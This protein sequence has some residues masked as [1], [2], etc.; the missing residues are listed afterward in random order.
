M[1]ATTI[2]VDLAKRV[3]EVAVANRTC[4]VIARHRFTRPQFE[5]FL[6]AQPPAHLVMEACASAHHWGRLAR[7]LGH[8]VSLIPAQYVRPYVQRNKTDRADAEAVLEAS[9][10]GRVHPVPVKTTSQQELLALHRIRQQWMTTRTARINA[11]R[12]FLHEHGLTL[13][14]GARAGLKALPALLADADNGLPPRLRQALGWLYE[15]IRTVEHHVAQLERELARAAAGDV[16]IQRLMGIPGIGLL[17]ATALVATVGDI[18]AFRR[19]R[20]FAS[21]LGLTP[22][23]HSSGARRRLGAISKQGDVYVRCLLVHGARALLIAARRTARQRHPLMRLQQW[24][25][26]LEQR[27][28]HNKT[29]VAIAN[30]LARI[31]WAVWTHDTEFC[32]RPALPQAA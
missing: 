5:R 11:I 25:V 10:S 8:R 15:E 4:R 30:K 12:A 2:G 28:G 23:E 22:K 13:A 1:D 7:Q 32:P 19:A 16:V 27:R 21:W 14:G 26:S 3:F 9:R 24:A 20:R 18:Y 29:T 17:T 6:R 31:V